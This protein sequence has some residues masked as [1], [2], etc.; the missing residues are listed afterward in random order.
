MTKGQL[1]KKQRLADERRA[2]RAQSASA[3]ATGAKEAVSGCPGADEART[4]AWRP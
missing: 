2:K 3:L 4:A 1:D